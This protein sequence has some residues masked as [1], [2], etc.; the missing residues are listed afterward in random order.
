MERALPE[1]WEALIQRRVLYRQYLPPEEREALG[2]L[3]QVF[4]DEKPFEGCAGLEINDEIRLTVAGHACILLLGGQSD[5]YPKLR[6]VLVYPSAYV[7][8]AAN[9]GP[10][11][12]VTEGLEGRSGESWSFGNV[13]LSW[14]DVLRDAGNP[15]SGRNVVFHEFAHQLDFESG[16][17]KGAPVLPANAPYADWARVFEREYEA[18]IDSVEQGR[19]SLLDEYGAT[20][21]A[22][23]FAVATE[24][25]FLKPAELELH[26]SELYRQLKLYY[27]QPALLLAKKRTQIC[28]DLH[29]FVEI[30]VKTRVSIKKEP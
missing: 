1:T 30:R 12:T 3:V 5:M 7:A 14:R 15:R 21:P 6:T 24:C 18:L 8:P 27:R 29:G 28:A 20:N 19:R 10:D 13:V 17:G 11:G 4:L 16:S 26:H 23:F 25:F 9:H 2:G 22:E